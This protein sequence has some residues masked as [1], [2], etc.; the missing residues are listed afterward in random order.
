MSVSCPRIAK[1][2]PRMQS[3]IPQA[4]CSLV[5]SDLKIESETAYARCSDWYRLISI[6]TLKY[7][8]VFVSEMELRSLRKLT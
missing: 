1:P 4:K 3:L 2:V 8:A 5:F 6:P 7:G